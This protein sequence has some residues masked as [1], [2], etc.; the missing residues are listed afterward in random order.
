MRQIIIFLI[1]GI[2]SFV[3]SQNNLIIPD[4]L[5]GTSFNLNLQY[6]TFEFYPGVQ[7]NTMGTNG[8]ILG[9]TLIMNKG[10]FVDI[11]VTNQLDDTT[12]IHWHG[13]HVSAA[14]DGGPHTT[15]APSETWNPRFTVL[16]KASTFWYHPHLHEKTNLH[17]SKGI[18]G[19][20]IVR[21]EVEAALELPRKYGVDDFP[22]V[23]QTKT[24]DADKEIVVPSNSD[25]VVMVNVTLDALLE[26]PAQVVRLRL[27]NGSSQR[28]FNVGLNNN[29]LFYQ[30][31]SDGGL[32]SKPLELTRLQLAPG[33]RGEILIDF[34]SAEGE[35]VYLMSYA[36][37][38][39]NGIYGATNP[40]VNTMQ[41]LNGYSPNPINGTDFNLMQFKVVSE[42]VNPVKTI[43]TNLV[44]VT[45]L[46]E[47]D[48]DITRDI[49]LTPVSMG[50]NVLNGDFLINNVSFDMDVINYT[51]P[52]NNTEIWSITNQSPIAHPFH[53]HDV[54]F[55]ILDRDGTIPPPS[56]QGL[57][58]VI[59]INPMETIRFITKFEDFADDEV[60]YMYHC[61]M[62]THEDRGMMGQFIVVSTTDVKNG[63]SETPEKFELSQNYPNPFN[64]STAIKFSL[65]ESAFT[66][67]QIFDILGSEV[68]TLVNEK[69]NA[70]YYEVVFDA[71][72]L[73][74]GTYI[75]RIIASDF[76]S[77]KKMTLIK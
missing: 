23:I 43:P 3:Y 77:S 10:D 31:G 27:L 18:A 47:S 62:L 32:L 67:I 59:L 66:K 17:V 69:R 60:P 16:D 53:I 74:S 38:F 24:F 64:P 65:K 76:A 28:V 71:S 52:L 1:F 55:Y 50:A 14:N 75:Y 13:M 44:T 68:A 5:S 48:A 41:T 73:V 57:K 37:E 70:G 36:S 54:Q 42:T 51:I 2:T 72:N 26:V 7:T 6:G 58:D 21:D 46:N 4:T 39:P 22:L 33:E 8:D 19:F 29:K 15:I 61:H 30:I 34:S 40:G 45:P 49:T 25:S 56:E 12:T 20:I 63:E 11:K 35:T 9:P